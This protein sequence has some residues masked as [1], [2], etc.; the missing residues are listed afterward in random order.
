[1]STI[2]KRDF[3]FLTGVHFE[4]TYLINQFHLVLTMSV[5]TDSIREQNVAMDRIKYF[6]YECLENSVMVS[7]AEKKTTEK[8]MAAGM[9]ICTLPD[10]PYDQIVVLVLAN[11]INAICEGRLLL[12]DIELKS[13]LSDDVSFVYEFETILVT[14]P[15]R[16]GW[17]MDSTTNISDIKCTN[18]KEKI[19][20]LIKSSDWG[21][22]QLDWAEKV[23]KPMEIIFTPDTEK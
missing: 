9:K 10:E 21:N 19:V 4:G 13:T 5:E 6:L 23:T 14:N 15:Y 22:V 7:E 17:W 18:K 16:K 8:Y 3:D 1:L 12:I 2:I 20:K 11:K